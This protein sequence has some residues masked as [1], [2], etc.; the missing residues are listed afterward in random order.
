MTIDDPIHDQVFYLNEDMR[1]RLWD[2]YGVRGWRIFQNVGDA[3]FV[4]AG[5]AHQV[6]NYMDCIKVCESFY[7]SFFPLT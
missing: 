3:V 6:C 4:P 5:C 2:E 1:Q 7:F